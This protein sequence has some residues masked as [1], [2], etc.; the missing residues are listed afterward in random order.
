[1]QLTI[2]RPSVPLLAGLVVIVTAACGTSSPAI[3]PAPDA[4]PA[5]TVHMPSVTLV[6]GEETTRCV[7]LELPNP[8]PQIL[9]RVHSVIGARESSWWACAS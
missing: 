7:V 8:A 9:R 2:N 6:P 3:D 4:M 1:M 5:T